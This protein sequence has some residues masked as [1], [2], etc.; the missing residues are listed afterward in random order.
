MERDSLPPETAREYILQSGG[1]AIVAASLGVPYDDVVAWAHAGVESVDH[2]VALVS[3]AHFGTRRRGPRG[4]CALVT[5]DQLWELVGRYQL[6]AQA[7]RALGTSERA[8]RRYLSG[9]RVAPA[10][11]AEK[12]LL[13]LSPESTPAALDPHAVPEADPASD[14][15]P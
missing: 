14:H 2:S 12:V 4:R 11:V 7:A 10:S 1:T 3:L 15:L 5:G 6:R 9:E 8:L 13:A